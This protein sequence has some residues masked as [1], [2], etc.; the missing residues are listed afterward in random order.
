MIVASLN[1]DLMVFESQSLKDKRR[2]IKSI[3]SVLH[4]RFEVSVAE[5]DHAD[6]I[7]RCT[8]GVA[9][10]SNESRAVHQ[11]FD[12]IV[13]AIRARVDVSLLDYTRELY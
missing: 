9:M 6:S 8:L 2:V 5:V 12:K 7:K 10:V 11:R 1:L 13:D 4:G 3:K